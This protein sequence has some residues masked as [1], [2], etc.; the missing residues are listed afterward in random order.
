MIEEVCH[1][2][3]RILHSPSFPHDSYEYHTQAGQ[4]LLKAGDFRICATEQ[5]LLTGHTQAAVRKQ[6]RAAS[7]WHR[8]STL[9][10]GG[11]ET[12]MKRAT[13]RFACVLFK[14][15]HCQLLTLILQVAL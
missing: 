4:S 2:K 9:A 10:F 15:T 11:W 6:H 3:L 8:C 1:V 5:R 12:K 13:W 7:K 14:C